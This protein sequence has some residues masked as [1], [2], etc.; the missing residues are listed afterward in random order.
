MRFAICFVFSLLLA[1]CQKDNAPG[2]LKA[3]GKITS[4]TR[5]P[6]AFTAIRLNSKMDLEIIQGPNCEVTF[7]CGEHLLNKLSAEIRN[8]TLLLDNHNTCNVVRGYKKGIRVSVTLPLLKALVNNSVARITASGMVQ[9]S[10]YIKTESSGDVHVEGRFGWLRCVSSGNG[11]I[12]LSGTAREFFAFANGTNYIRADDLLVSDHIQLET[13]TL[14]DCYLNA[15][16]LHLL[17]Y[18]IRKTGRV[19]Y[20][21]TPLQLRNLGDSGAPSAQHID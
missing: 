1:C 3:S 8:D 15:T 9:D 17:D 7:T 21:G 5:Q 14:G 11:D 13:M 19:F 10:L 18:A 20:H 16:G 4:A 2:C 6:G 12:Y